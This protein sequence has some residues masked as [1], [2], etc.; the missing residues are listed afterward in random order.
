MNRVI[1]FLRFWYEFIVGDDWRVAAGVGVAIA[2]TALLAGAGIS[3]WWVIPL[4]V[5]GTVYASLRRATRS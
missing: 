3:S 5:V 2:L 4:V 1:A